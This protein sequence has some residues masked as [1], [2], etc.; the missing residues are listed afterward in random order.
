MYAKNKQAKDEGFPWSRITHKE[1]K[2]KQNGNK[3][4]T[5][6]TILRNHSQPSHQMQDG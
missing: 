2:V 6:T 3:T 4:R 1:E 5:N